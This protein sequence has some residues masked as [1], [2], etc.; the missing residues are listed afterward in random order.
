[1][2]ASEPADS[3]VEDMGCMGELYGGEAGSSLSAWIGGCSVFRVGSE[4]LPVCMLGPDMEAARVGVCIG[5]TG[6]L[7]DCE[8]GW[9]CSIGL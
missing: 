1:M 5:W 8:R 6:W 3:A 7:M 9:Y 4:W 2:D